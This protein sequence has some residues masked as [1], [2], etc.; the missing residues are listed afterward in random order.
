MNLGSLFAENQSSSQHKVNSSLPLKSTITRQ[1][2]PEMNLNSLFPEDQSS[3]QHKK[4]VLLPMK[5]TLSRQDTPEMNLSILFP[6]VAPIFSQNAPSHEPFNAP[7]H[8][9]HASG[10]QSAAGS[11]TLEMS[12]DKL[13]LEDQSSSQHKKKPSS[14]L[15]HAPIRQDTP[16]MNL[17]S[18]FPENQSIQPTKNA[19]SP[20]KNTPIRQDT[21]EMNL[22]TLFPEDQSPSQSKKNAWSPLKS[23]LTRQETPEMGLD[24]LFPEDS[25]SGEAPVSNQHTRSHKPF[26]AP[27][28]LAHHSSK[29]SAAG[30]STPEMNLGSLFEDQSPSHPKMKA[31][32]PLKNTPTRQDT[33]EMDLNNLFLEE[34][35][36]SQSKKNVSS[37]LKNT[38]MR[39]G[40][41]EMNLSKLFNDLPTLT[42]QPLPGH[43]HSVPAHRPKKDTNKPDEDALNDGL[44]G[45]HQ[46]MRQP[47]QPHSFVQQ[48]KKKASLPLKA[49]PTRQDTPEMN[50]GSL[51]PE[52]QSTSQ[53]MK[54]ASSPLKATPTRQ[55]TPEMNLNTLFHEDQ[56]VSQLKKSAFS[57][58]KGVLTRQDTPEMNFNQLFPEDTPASSVHVSHGIAQL[59]SGDSTKP[60][61]ISIADLL[62]DSDAS[63][64]SPYDSPAE[65]KANPFTYIEPHA[66]PEQT[67][68]HATG[69]SVAGKAKFPTMPHLPAIPSI[70]LPFFGAKKVSIST[71]P[72]LHAASAPGLPSNNSPWISVLDVPSGSAPSISIPELPALDSSWIS[73]PELPSLSASTLPAVSIVELPSHNAQGHYNAAA[74]RVG[75]TRGVM[76]AMPSMSSFSRHPALYPEEEA[77]FP[78]GDAPRHENPVPSHVEHVVE[79]HKAPVKSH[80]VAVF[81]ADIPS[82]EKKRGKRARKAQRK[83]DATRR[84]SIM[85]TIST[86]LVGRKKNTVSSPV[87]RLNELFD[88]PTAMALPA[89]ATHGAPLLGGI[90][91]MLPTMPTMPALSSVHLPSMPAMPAVPEVHLPAFP[92]MHLPA[93]PEMH[94]P[95][96]P[97][98]PSLAMP[99]LPKLGSVAEAGVSGPT[100]LV[101]HK[102]ST[103]AALKVPKIDTTLL[104]EEQADY[105]RGDVRRYE[106]PPP[107]HAHVK[108]V[109]EIK[110][111]RLPQASPLLS[112]LPPLGLSNL[113]KVGVAAIPSVS[114]A[115]ILPK[116]KPSTSAAL[117]TPKVDLTLLPEEQANYPRGDVRRHENPAPSHVEDIIEVKKLRLPPALP[118]MPAL[119]I[120]AL[121]RQQ[122]LGA[123][124]AHR[125]SGPSTLSIHKP[126]KAAAIKMPKVDLTLF[127]E[128]QANYPRGDISRREN[129]TP[130][131]VEDIVEVK[132]VRVPAPLPLNAGKK[133]FSSLRAINVHK[134]DKNQNTQ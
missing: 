66:H 25:S 94:M 128:E 77:D 93:L 48:K 107:S 36:H 127:P 70:S 96:M 2:T 133:T 22:N 23:T 80:S 41:P 28:H 30:R 5:S 108:D 10:K 114:A 73:A 16:E 62:D 67:D 3:P 113:P 13:F 42:T 44:S 110:K 61:S 38:P 72:E 100:T 58:L 79:I 9:L 131:H 78:R 122:K 83:H 132:K 52:E 89:P 24:K 102:P 59:A 76:P 134:Q 27:T 14:P 43:T 69:S 32:S 74:P 86:A 104:P 92:E 1:E 121:D 7:V 75:G 90:R 45:H 123:V 81:R 40:S 53:S 129:P 15:K 87:M 33:P 124:T 119:P 105:P 97:V 51:F 115:A 68:A 17:G 88:E 47:R 34:Q 84:H 46:H 126:S 18:L 95:S 120:L 4:N 103:A 50:L 85:E 11:G 117:K 91:S 21:P 101:K 99:H 71:Q 8:L 64:H 19:S 31:S 116:R 54:K 65:T 29:Q 82:H 63:D 49:T 12:L 112:V 98:M 56:S 39:H 106:N 60:V 55:D 37:P 20:L 130:S 6:E 109:V 26:S 111:L 125:V 118:L 57:P 35:L